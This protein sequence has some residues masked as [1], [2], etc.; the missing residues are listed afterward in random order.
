MPKV[1]THYD[2]L[3]IARDAPIEV[4]EAAYRSL[5]QKYHPDRSA[6]K[7]APR[8]M[9][10]INQAYSVLS[11][12]E[13]RRHHDQWI[14]QTEANAHADAEF[15][16]VLTEPTSKFDW[17][18]L[19][20]MPAAILVGLAAVLGLWRL[21]T[22]TFSPELATT[23]AATFYPS[24][25]MPDLTLPITSPSIAAPDV[26]KVRLPKINMPDDSDGW[27]P[28]GPD[29]PISQFSA[30]KV[31]VRAPDATGCGPQ[32]QI[33][34]T[35]LIYG[36]YRDQGAE[37]RDW[38]HLTIATGDWAGSTYVKVYD[39]SKSQAV[40][41]GF[42]RQG[43][44][45]EV[46]LKPGVYKIHYASVNRW[47]GEDHVGEEGC[48]ATGAVESDNTIQLNSAVHENGLKTVDTVTIELW[49]QIGGN[50]GTH[51]IPLDE[52]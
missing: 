42:I 17:R 20:R 4:I 44:R 49:K 36:V 31:K 6:S 5:A 25:S 23:P 21:S 47:Y 52:L 8:I 19:R 35:S 29:I 51:G 48:G 32:L 30:Q 9:A 7:N 37:E 3:K 26:A 33:P 10:L 11:N 43:D 34:P 41:S 28:V 24:R 40:A 46:R 13:L 1:R 2:N 14:H 15:V 22:S 16:E 27:Q 39:T 38:P 12:A 50:F 45:A 18:S